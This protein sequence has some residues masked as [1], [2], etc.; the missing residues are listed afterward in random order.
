MTLKAISL[1]VLLSTAAVP[2]L[3]TSLTVEQNSADV[4]RIEGLVASVVVGNPMIADVTVLDN[5]MLVVH[6]RLFGSTNVLVFDAN[7]QALENLVVTVGAPMHRHV[8]L[9][10]GGT[11]NTFVCPDNCVAIYQPGDDYNYTDEIFN[12]NREVQE[13]SNWALDRVEED[14][15]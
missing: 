14:P 9:I 15:Q 11:Q 8:A 12:Q 1:A 4:V 7:G 3:A 10:R 13:L 6:G 2:A 5:N